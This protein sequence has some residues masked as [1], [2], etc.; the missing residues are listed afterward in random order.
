MKILKKF[1]FFLPLFIGQIEAIIPLMSK[2]TLAPY[3]RTLLLDK[4]KIKFKSNAGFEIK[5]KTT[6]Q[7]FFEYNDLNG[8]FKA[9]NKTAHEPVKSMGE[10]IYNAFT[11]VAATVFC[12]LTF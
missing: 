12:I 8:N 4:N 7:Q 5:N 11:A 3:K 2:K 9:T 6:K 10:S 1:I